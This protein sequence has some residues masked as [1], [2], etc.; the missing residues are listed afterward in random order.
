VVRDYL[1]RIDLVITSKTKGFMQCP[2]LI[3]LSRFQSF[4]DKTF[5]SS[6]ILFDKRW[7]KKFPVGYLESTDFKT[8]NFLYRMFMVWGFESKDM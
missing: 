5:Q 2:K 8:G 6:E 1:C 3:R 7:D 4:Q